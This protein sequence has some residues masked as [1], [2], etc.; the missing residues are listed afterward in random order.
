MKTIPTSRTMARAAGGQWNRSIPLALILLGALGHIA[1]MS[2][3]CD[4]A[5]ITFRYASNLIHGHGLVFNIGERVEGYTNFLWLL[6]SALI[7][8]VGA[9][10]EV[11]TLWISGACALVT[12]SAL[13]WQLRRN[14]KEQFFSSIL[15]ASNGGFAAWSTGG[16]ETA[17]FTLLVF[18]AFLSVTTALESASGERGRIDG[19]P[20]RLSAFFLLLA[21]LTRPEGVL[22]TALFGLFLVTYA[23]RHQLPWRAL[24]LWAVVWVVPYGVYFIWRWQYY[25]H[26]FPNTFYVKAAGLSILPQGVA[27]ILFA[28]TR[29]HLYLVLLPGVIL[30]ILRRSWGLRRGVAWL[31]ATII[32]PYV[33]YVCLMGGDF[34]DMFRFVVPIL[35]IVMLSAGVSWAAFHSFLREKIPA[36]AV[37]A[38]IALLVLV[39]GLNLRTS[40]D[41]QTIWYRRGLDSIGLL[42]RYAENWTLIARNLP[43]LSQ[44][45]DTLATTAAGIIPYYTGLY[46]LDQLGLVAPDL[47]RYQRQKS[48]RPGH[49]LQISGEYLFR[50]KP[51]LILGHP[52]L[53]NDPSEARMSHFI[54][55]DWLDEMNREYR[56]VTAKI[57]TVPPR[58]FQIGLRRDVVVRTNT[59]VP[60]ASH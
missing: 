36:L 2:F 14:R 11:W 57:L 56:V 13:L 32:F 33:G 30:L 23:L 41:S 55:E 48:V 18:A 25:G 8:N 17:L 26:L 49:M 28:C 44:P 19:R 1:W 51:Q 21:S 50:V 24:F 42:R 53:V 43:R 37:P 27:H 22:L 60:P 31:S 58:Y 3:I 15:L 38:M 35:P 7:L 47:S 39:V 45:S 40:Q 20:I 6:V 12:V 4:D 54:Q 46:T 9:R 10:P 5:F 34:M 16:L 59:D 29:F 52:N